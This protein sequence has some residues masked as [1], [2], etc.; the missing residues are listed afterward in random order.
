MQFVTSRDAAKTRASNFCGFTQFEIE[1]SPTQCEDKF[2]DEMRAEEDKDE[3]GALLFS[4]REAWVS[5]RRARP[6]F[7]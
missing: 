4:P 1:T 2:R 3:P 6:A 5:V 7:Q